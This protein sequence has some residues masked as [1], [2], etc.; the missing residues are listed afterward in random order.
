MFLPGKA[1]SCTLNSLSCDRDVTVDNSMWMWKLHSSLRISYHNGLCLSIGTVGMRGWW[2]EDCCHILQASCCQTTHC[3]LTEHKLRKWLKEEETEKLQLILGWLRMCISEVHTTK[4]GLAQLIMHNRKQSVNVLM[5]VSLTA[6][7]S[8]KLR[9]NR[10]TLLE[11]SEAKQI[12]NMWTL[13]NLA[14]GCM[15]CCSQGDGDY[16]DTIFLYIHTCVCPVLSTFPCV[17]LFSTHQPNVQPNTQH[18]LL[19]ALSLNLLH[20]Q[21]SSSSHHHLFSHNLQQSRKAKANMTLTQRSIQKWESSF[22]WA[23]PVHPTLKNMDLIYFHFFYFMVRTWLIFQ[24][25]RLRGMYPDIIFQ[26]DNWKF[27]SWAVIKWYNK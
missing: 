4:A 14:W 23:A 3:L 27:P 1:R 9:A 2:E 24:R 25:T 18:T 11:Y 16:G 26:L 19:S 20:S 6:N 7:A 13:W 21:N 22:S 10:L 15:G 8:G 5:S 12:T 17:H